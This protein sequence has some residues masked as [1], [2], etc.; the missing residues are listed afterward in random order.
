MMHIYCNPVT[1]FPFLLFNIFQNILTGK[2]VTLKLEE[3]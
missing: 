2:A 3:K 1:H